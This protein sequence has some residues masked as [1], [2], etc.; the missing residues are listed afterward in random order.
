M[1]EKEVFTSWQHFLPKSP[2]LAPSVFVARTADVIGAVSVDE[3]SSIWF[4]AVIRADI[5]EIVV[6]QRTNIQDGCILHVADDYPVRIGDDV[7]CGHRAM[8]HACHIGDRVLV[9]MG[10]I[11]LDGAEIGSDSIIGA[12]TLVTKGTKV[13]PGS[14]VLGSPGKVI[15]S[16]RAEEIA[17][18]PR[19]AAKYAALAAAYQVRSER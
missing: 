11:I 4:Q 2:K 17:A 14:L 3:H 7:T 12:H 16:L 1:V 6:G 18:L 10:A 19:M 5:N 8:I 9:G 13:P 15:R